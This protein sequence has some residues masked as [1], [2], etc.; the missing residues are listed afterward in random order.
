VGDVTYGIFRSVPGVAQ[1][2]ALYKRDYEEFGASLV[3]SGLVL[4][5]GIGKRL[6]SFK[7]FGLIEF[8]EINYEIIG[9]TNKLGKV[10]LLNPAGRLDN[11]TACV[12]A[13]ILNK[14]WAR[15]ID[16]LVTAQEIEIKYGY[17]GAS[18]GLSETQSVA[19]IEN[20]TGAN[21]IKTP[22]AAQGAPVGNYAVYA[23]GPSGGHV[24][25]GQVLPNGKYYFYD[26]QIGGKALN[27]EQARA[28]YNLTRT[29]YLEKK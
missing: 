20:A 13:N 10:N 16:N 2:G 6:P 12:A 7:Q 11:C 17:V 19:Y 26:P 9:A 8:K 18:R 21:A 22:I 29:Y 23:T 4:A 3:D 27:L 24:L 1:I 14:L 15:S 28:R 5:P 25:Y